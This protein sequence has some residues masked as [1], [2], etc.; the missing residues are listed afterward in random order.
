MG[1]NIEIEQTTYVVKVPNAETQK[2]MREANEIFAKGEFRSM[3]AEE[4][5]DELDKKIAQ[6]P[7]RP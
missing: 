1:N 3:S 4:L 5:F 7:V 6:L 2:A